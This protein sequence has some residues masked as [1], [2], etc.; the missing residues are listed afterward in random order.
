MNQIIKKIYDYSLEDIMGERF[1]RYS[2]SIIQ[3]RAL[4]DVR[5][6]LKPVQRR[7]LY[8]MYRDKNTYDKPYQKSARS[9][10]NVMGKY[11]P[12]GDSSIYEAMVRMS[13]WWKQSTPFIDMHGNNGSMDGDSPAAMRYTEARLSKIAVE[14]LKDI[15]KETVLWSPNYDDTLNEPTVL[16]S[17]YPNLLVNGSSGISAGYATNIPPHNLG[18]IVEATIKRIESPNCQFE[19]L[20]NIVKGPD[21]PTGGIVYGEDGIRSAFQTGRGKIIHQAKYEITKGKVKQ[22]IIHEIP[23]DVN[24][25]NLVKKIDEIRLDKK[26]D[27]IIEIR[28]ESDLNSPMRV[29]IDI[30]KEADEELIVNY[31]LKN[32][33]LQTH[34]SYNMVAIVGKRPTTVSLVEILDAFIV[35]QKEVILHRTDFDLRFAKKQHHILEGLIKAISILDDVIKTIRESKNRT[36]AKDNL[37]EKYGFTEEQAVA[38][39]DLQLYRLTNTD[40]LELKERKETLEKIIKGLQQIIDDE[41]TLKQVMKD[42][43]KKIKKEYATERKS[44]IVSEIVDIKIDTTAMIPKE[45]VVVALSKDGYI[46]RVSKRS[47]GSS[48]KEETELKEGDYTLLL[49]NANTL[50][51]VLVFTNLGN[52]MYIPVHE[53]PEFKWGELGKHISSMFRLEEKEKLINAFAIEEFSKKNITI[54]T[55]KGLVKRTALEEFK[56]VRY[57]KPVSSIKLK[58]SDEVISVEINETNNIIVVTERGFAL[59]FTTEEVPITGVKTSGVKAISLKEDVVVSANFFEEEEFLLIATDKKTCKRIKIDD[60]KSGTRARKVTRVIREVVTNPYRIKKALILNS[61][62]E[63]GIKEKQ[64]VYYLKTSEIPI[65]DLLSTGKTITKQNIEDIF[66]TDSIEE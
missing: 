16:P 40:V 55:K 13:Q 21:F 3:D 7:I 59:K 30:K 15:D 65:V 25:S 12:H 31:L 8:S 48:N 17:K 43:L 32:T 19:T 51:T 35:H 50:D 62:D 47:Y 33:D 24:K 46:K 37:K 22:I 23:F 36:D 10:G 14:Q 56:L 2:K 27:G 53:I 39:V 11:H 58:A 63:I 5:D 28:D 29:V 66:I 4:P 54:F 49:S 44:E 34:F 18:E 45:D 6:G 52:Y 26:L 60:I 42:E 38:I 20:M 61:R 1:G 57:S 64:S 9:V 41:E